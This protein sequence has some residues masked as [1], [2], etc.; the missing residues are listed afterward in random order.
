MTQ[1]FQALVVDQTHD[2]EVQAEVRSLKTDNLPAGEVLIRVAYSSINYKDGLAARKDGNI[3]K[4]YPF[5][6]GIDCSGTV[7][8][9]EDSR[10]SEGQAVL[11]TGY[12]LGVS[13]FGGFSQYARVPADWVV[14]LP[15]GLTL[16]EAMIFGTAG[17]TAALSLYRLEQNDVAPE[18][19]KVLVT[20]ATGGV[21]GA[22]IALLHKRG[23][24]VVA[25]SGKADSHDYLKALGAADV[26]S[27]E[28]VYDGAESIRPLAKQL[29]QAA[30]D[31][32]GGKPLASLLSQIAYN[33]SVAVSGLTAGTKLPTTVLPFILR[34]V[35]LLGI[36]SVFCPYDTRVAI[37]KH[38]GSD[39]K[40]EQLEQLVE[41]EIDLADLPSALEDILA[42][43]SQGRTIVRLAD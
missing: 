25:S 19:G 32:V 11:V 22:A 17:F 29:W 38:L 24:H 21:G 10:F 33:G 23:Y 36:D 39:W 43:R 15:D 18:K 28:E 42:A 9:S 16:R 6:P 13:Q 14:P 27:R 20:G 4:S 31:P 7:V 41:R 34:G 5:V 8:S 40:P 37:W 1:S 3:V 30:V 12:G 26:I 35:N 2:G